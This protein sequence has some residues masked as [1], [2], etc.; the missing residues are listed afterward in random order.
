NEEDGLA[1][2]RLSQADFDGDGDT[3]E[4]IAGEVE[5][6]HEALYAAIQDYGVETIG[7]GI[8][9][10]GHRYPYF[11][12]DAGERFTTWAP[13]LLKAAYNYQ[14]VAKDPGAF[15]HNPPYAIQILYDSLEDLGADVSG[16]TRP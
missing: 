9:Y 2:I 6:L 11:F 5:T 15:A 16:F 10:D 4:G 14:Y 7:T 1:T 12:D 3:D 8:V 13:R